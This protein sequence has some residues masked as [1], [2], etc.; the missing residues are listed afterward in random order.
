MKGLMKALGIMDILCAAALFLAAHLPD[1]LITFFALYLIFKGGF[2]ALGKDFLSFFDIGI[3]LYL[4]YAAGHA[5]WLA[6]TIIMAIY[7]LIKGG[8]SL[9]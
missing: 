4:L 3:G 2:F 9:F 6:L 8:I 7:L 1:K 5:G